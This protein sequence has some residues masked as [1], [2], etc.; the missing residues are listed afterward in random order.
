MLKAELNA[1]RQT[2]GAVSAVQIPGDPDSAGAQFFVNVGDQPGLEGKYTIFGRVTA[3]I[4]VVERI[5]AAALDDKGRLIDRLEIRK[6]TIRDRPPEA[7]STEKSERSKTSI[8]L[9]SAAAAAK[10]RLAA[11]AT[12]RA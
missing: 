4:E 5:S 1:E 12:P 2:R 8:A 10:S 6:V 3:G 7:F 9:A 11:S